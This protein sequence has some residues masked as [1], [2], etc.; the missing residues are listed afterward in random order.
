MN[1]F[2]NPL[3]PRRDPSVERLIQQAEAMVAGLEGLENFVHN[4]TE[5]NAKIVQEA[6]ERGDNERRL[7]IDELNRT[8][9]TPIDRED[10]FALS[11]SIDDI[12]DYAYS[13]VDE[14]V[15]F[16]LQPNDHLTKMAEMM[17]SAGKEIRLAMQHI[18]AHPQ[19]ANEHAVK[20]KQMEN[21][22]EKVYRE[23]TCDLFSGKVT[24]VEGVLEILKTREVLRHL[25]NAADRADTTA[26]IICD[27]IMKVM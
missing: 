1:V 21:G 27:V 26:N 12:L 6:E 3:K 25:S 15:L 19:V 20:A 16:K 5:A 14:M 13:T 4:P 8:F 2:C 18:L 22:V 17:H 24:T 23:A 7:L 9:V 10:L 11:R